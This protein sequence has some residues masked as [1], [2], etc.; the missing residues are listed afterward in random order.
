[1]SKWSKIYGSD[2][3]SLDFI[4]CTFLSISNQHL[5]AI[6]RSFSKIKEILIVVKIKELKICLRF[7]RSVCMK[8]STV[9]QKS[10]DFAVLQPVFDNKFIFVSRMCKDGVHTYVLDLCTYLPKWHKLYFIWNAMSENQFSTD[11]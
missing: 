3:I 10:F 11:S 5:D 8:I 7:K 2:Q 4:V 9:N 6:K 1:M